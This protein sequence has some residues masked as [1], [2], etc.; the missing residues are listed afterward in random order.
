MPSGVFSRPMKYPAVVLFLLAIC[1]ATASARDQ[2]ADNHNLWLNYVGDHPLSGSP[3]GLHLE[4]QVRREDWGDEWQ[5]LLLRPGVNYQIS[6]TLSASAGWAYVRTYPYGEL[7][8]AHEFDEHRAWEQ[9]SWRTE[10]L[11]LEW[12]HRF[13]LEQR[14][15]EEQDARGNRLDWRLE[16]RFR[17]MLRA[18][19]P[20]TA[21]KKT[22]L[23]LWNEVFLNFGGNIDKNHFDQNR[24][25]IGI[26]RKLSD[27]TRIEIGF[28]E[29][30]VQRRGGDKLENNHTASVWLMSAWPFGR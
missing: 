13:R 25:F 12:Q 1:E 14:W 9:V 2:H 20:L 15:L 6:P 18:S 7:P 23:A 30:T 16:N 17:Y 29:Q 22:Y 5:Q 19:V 8:V 27:H 24:A 10:M 28:L 26:G 21:N 3:W 4:A 11:G